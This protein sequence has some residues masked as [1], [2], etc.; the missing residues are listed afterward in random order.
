[1][2]KDSKYIKIYSVNSLHLTLNTVNG[3]FEEINRNKYLTLIPTNESNEKAKIYED[4][5][6]KDRDLIRSVSKNSDD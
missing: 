3:Y 1:M 4:I 2:I 6:S 5:W